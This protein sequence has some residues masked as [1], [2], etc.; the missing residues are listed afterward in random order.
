MGS[1]WHLSEKATI[2][3]QQW[4]F[5]FLTEKRAFF[6][7]F[8]LQA[9]R[10]A[11]R[12]EK[13][14]HCFFNSSFW[15]NINAS[16]LHILF[17]YIHPKC[18]ISQ[19]GKNLTFVENLLWAVLYISYVKF[20]DVLHLRC[21]KG[22]VKWYH[23]NSKNEKTGISFKYLFQDQKAQNMCKVIISTLNSRLLESKTSAL[24]II[25]YLLHRLIPRLTWYLVLSV[26]G[27]AHLWFST[28]SLSHYSNTIPTMSLCLGIY[29]LL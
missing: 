24:F 29:S 27:A 13:K 8:I 7:I 17:F 22:T 3:S 4:D 5:T 6:K 20:H 23:L 12:G 28:L 25:L 18:S 14:K 11:E 15:R 26:T 19:G 9:L 16:E 1:W 10:T 2:F 21:K